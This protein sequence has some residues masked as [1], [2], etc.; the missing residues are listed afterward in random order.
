M[1][2]GVKGEKEKICPAGPVPSELSFPLIRGMLPQRVGRRCNGEVFFLA[3]EVADEAVLLTAVTQ[4]GGRAW[5]RPYSTG[6]HVCT[7]PCLAHKT[8][9]QFL[10]IRKKREGGKKV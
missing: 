1:P 8:P 10:G 9:Y 2:P 7:G 5:R 6:H 4:G 3:S